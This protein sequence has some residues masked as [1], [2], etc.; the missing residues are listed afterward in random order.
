MSDRLNQ[1]SRR[2][3]QIMEIIYQMGSAT[4][5]DIHERLPDEPSYSTVRALLRILE[6][7]GFLAHKNQGTKYVYHPTV[8]KETAVQSAVTNLL[9]TFFNNSVEQAVAALIEHDRAK[10]SDDDFSRLA[11]LIEKTRK[12]GQ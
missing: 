6:E 3:R 5:Q 10:M 7:K 2:E 8:A 4:A 11:Q 9:K 12:E 1:L